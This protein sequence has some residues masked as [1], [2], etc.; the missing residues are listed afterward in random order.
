MLRTLFYDIL[1]PRF[2]LLWTLTSGLSVVRSIPLEPIDGQTS[3][4]VH[5]YPLKSIYVIPID[6]EV[7]WSE[8]K[9]H[10]T[11]TLDFDQ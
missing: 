11:G 6:F 3:N 10:T 9:G 1:T 2:K 8:V 7:M 4:L 5:R